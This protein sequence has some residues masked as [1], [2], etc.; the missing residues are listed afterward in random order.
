MYR[1]IV[2]R[3]PVVVSTSECK[4]REIAGRAMSA[5]LNAEGD[6]ILVQR[7]G[8]VKAYPTFEIKLFRG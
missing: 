7:I 1:V 2:M 8:E 3:G 4:L 5:I 6:K